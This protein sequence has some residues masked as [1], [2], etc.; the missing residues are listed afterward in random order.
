MSVSGRTTGRRQVL[1]SSSEIVFTGGRLGA[2]VDPRRPSVMRLFSAA[3]G[4]E[5]RRRRSR[6]ACEGS[7]GVYDG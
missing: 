6:A 1:S 7:V 5:G 4:T 2:F 3:S